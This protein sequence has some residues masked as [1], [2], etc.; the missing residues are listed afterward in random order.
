M[1]ARWGSRGWLHMCLCMV[2]FCLMRGPLAARRN[3]PNQRK[4]YARRNP[5]LRQ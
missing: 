3:T 1:R 2:L 4:P 5:S